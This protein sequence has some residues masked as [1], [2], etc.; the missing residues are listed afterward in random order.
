MGSAEPTDAPRVLVTLTEE[1]TSTAVDTISQA[2]SRPTRLIA[3][4]DTKTSE[5]TGIHADALAEALEK[6][7]KFFG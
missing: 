3:N 2:G 6:A 7:R 5:R 1:P 4:E